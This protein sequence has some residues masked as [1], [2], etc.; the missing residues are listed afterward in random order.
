MTGGRSVYDIPMR[1]TFYA[2]VSTDKTEQ[3]GSLGNQVQY[4]TDL[5]KGSANW[6]YVEGYIDEG[7]SGTDT[8]RRDGF[9][10]MIADA[11]AGLFDFIITK[12]ISRFS[13]STLDSIRY[14]QELLAR[15]VGVLFQNDNINTLDPDSEF[16]LVV[17]AG[18]AQDEVRKLSERL[19]FGFRQ[20]IKNGR[21]LGNGAI[22]GYDK[23]NGRLTINESEAEAVRLIFGL[24][25]DQKLGFR[26]ISQALTARGHL[27]RNGTAFNTVTI[28]HI[29]LNPKYKGWY[30]GNKTRSVDYRSKKTEFLD[31]REWVCHPDPNIPALVSE[32]L[33][34]RAYALYRMRSAQRKQNAASFQNRY[35]YSGKI[36]CEDHGANY[37]RQ[38]LKSGRGEKEVWQCSIYRQRGR[39]GCLAPQLS[40]YELDA[41][42]ARI[43]LQR[44][45][46]REALISRVLSVLNRSGE[47][48]DTARD[49]SRIDREMVALRAKKDRLLQLHMEGAVGLPELKSRNDSFNRQAEKLQMRKD[50]LLLELRKVGESGKRA[51][52]IGE[53][54]DRKLRF[55]EGIDSELV[56]AGVDRIA[57]KKNSRGTQVHLD[58]SLKNG[59]RFRAEY[60]NSPFVCFVLNDVR[61]QPEI[62]FDQ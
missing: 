45:P 35:A 12:E 32:E 15:G 50:T 36:V 56:A 39:A 7:V 47:K 29:L 8:K 44:F 14:T 55:A 24:Y 4:Y 23:Q 41:I 13:R 18:V 53:W 27:S 28:R 62:V 19:K 38:V 16:R 31:M 2:R 60:E 49:I 25:A 22:W 37:H 59:S 42:M 9:L 26:R 51:A 10:R 54:L 20:S 46:D 34:E 11:K 1:V 33:W 48:N 40:K 17:M 57:V 3:I 52:Q 61:Y 30:C 43:F 6:T 5:I 58:I 21:V